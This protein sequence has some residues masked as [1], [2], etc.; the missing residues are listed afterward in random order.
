VLAWNPPNGFTDI[1]LRGPYAL[2]EHQ[3]RFTQVSGGTVISD[4]VTYALPFAPFSA[5]AR[6]FVHRDVEHIF[7]YRREEITRRFNEVRPRARMISS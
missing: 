7:R 2:W 5:I 3:H 4:D 1:Q 6:P